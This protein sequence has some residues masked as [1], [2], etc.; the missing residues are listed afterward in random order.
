MAAAGGLTR[1]LLPDNGTGTRRVDQGDI[2]AFQH[3]LAAILLDRRLA[4]ELEDGI[5]PGVVIALDLLSG[6][7]KINA[8]GGHRADF[9]VAGI[10][11]VDLTVEIISQRTGGKLPADLIDFANQCW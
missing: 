2:A 10:A 6:A 4:R 3:R 7:I 1:G 9:Q 11:G 8:A 5:K